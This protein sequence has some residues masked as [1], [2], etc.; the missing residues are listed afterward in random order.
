MQVCLE[1][2]VLGLH[3]REI[4]SLIAEADSQ[5]HDA[6][7]TFEEFIPVAAEMLVTMLAHQL[8]PL[9]V[10]ASDSG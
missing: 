3:P 10:P 1:S 8:A 6:M 7:I 5:V 2:P 9:H 4:K